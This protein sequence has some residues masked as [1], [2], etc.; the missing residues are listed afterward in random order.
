MEAKAALGSPFLT[1]SRPDIMAIDPTGRF[2]YVPSTT[3]DNVWVH[4]IDADS[5]VLTPVPGSPFPAG[6]TPN[7]VAVDPS[8]Q[9]VYVSNYQSSNVS[10]YVID[11]GSGA[12]TPISGSPPLLPLPVHVIKTERARFA[13]RWF[14]KKYLYAFTFLPHVAE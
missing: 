7:A 12:L 13:R 6:T 1:A 3:L 5:G 14:F 10:G 4:A 11:P 8:G 9:F 2:L